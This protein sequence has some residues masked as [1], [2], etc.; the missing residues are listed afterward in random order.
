M[1]VN[2]SGRS[3]RSDFVEE[4]R[5][6]RSGCDIEFDFDEA[7][8]SPNSL[9]ALRAVEDTSRMI[10]DLA[11]RLGCLGHFEPADGPRAA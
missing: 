2:T 7:E 10:D 5:L 6:V 4:L 11:R 1:S 8:L 3:N 9:R